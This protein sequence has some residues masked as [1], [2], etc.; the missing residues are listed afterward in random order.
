MMLEMC[1]LHLLVSL[2]QRIQQSGH[3]RF[4]VR[5]PTCAVN[6]SRYGDE[7]VCRTGHIHF[8]TLAAVVDV[9]DRLVIDVVFR[10]TE[11]TSQSFAGR[12]FFHVSRRKDG[13][14]GIRRIVQRT[15]LPDTVVDIKSTD[16]V[17]NSNTDTVIAA[18]C[19]GDEGILEIRK[20]TQVID[21]CPFSRCRVIRH[22]G[23]LAVTLFKLPDTEAA[24]R[25][26]LAR[27]VLDVHHACASL[28][29]Q[30]CIANCFLTAASISCFFLAE[31]TRQSR[32]HRTILSMVVIC[33]TNRMD[34]SSPS[35]RSISQSLP[36]TGMCTG[37]SS[38]FSLELIG[39]TVMIGEL[40]FAISLLMTS[41]GRFPLC[42]EVP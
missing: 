7:A 40:R 31:V 6:I 18:H 3:R 19:I 27:N 4:I 11:E 23:L 24:G 32:L 25:F 21:L 38:F 34:S 1:L 26:Q 41:T 16:S 2:H 17:A 30:A 9:V 35:S 42:T 12:R 20:C 39:I 28:P 22:L 8:Q 10:H 29:I 5:D 33:S 37:R 36:V 14:D 15:I 13:K